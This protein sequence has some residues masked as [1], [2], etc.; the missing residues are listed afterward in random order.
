MVKIQPTK[1]CVNCGDVFTKSYSASKKQWN[2]QTFCGYKCRATKMPPPRQ[3]VI[4][5][6]IC[7]NCGKEYFMKGKKAREMS[8]YCSHECSIQT[9]ENHWNWKGGV[10]PENHRLRNT[11]EYHDWRHA[12]YTRDYWTCQHCGKKD[13]NDI[14]AHHLKCFHVYVELRHEVSN[15]LTLCRSCHKKV[16]DDIGYNTRFKTN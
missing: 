14:V 1:E 4:T 5:P 8:K 13:R 3:G 9:G 16:H 2:K 6:K 7:Q 11:K 12:V 10:T 15:G